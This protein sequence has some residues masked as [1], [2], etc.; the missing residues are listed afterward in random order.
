ME[1]GLIVTVVAVLGAVAAIGTGVATTAVAALAARSV[2]WL[3]VPKCHG[4]QTSANF[5]QSL[6]HVRAA[7]LGFFDQVDGVA[8]A[9]VLQHLRIEWVEGDAFEAVGMS[10]RG[11]V[12]TERHIKVA[13]RNGDI[14]RTA[15]F[16]ELARLANAQQH[17]GFGSQTEIHQRYGDAID[18]AK[19]SY[20]TAQKFLV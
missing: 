6:E 13:I 8:V 9:K 14:G 18:A 4:L 2:Q 17:K 15:L 12:L 11:Q 10:L 1:I 19:R 7:V 5:P 20:A 16:W 3:E